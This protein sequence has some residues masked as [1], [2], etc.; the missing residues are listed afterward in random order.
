MGKWDKR[1]A[2][3]AEEQCLFYY[4]RAW[5][6]YHLSYQES[7][8]DSS[9]GKESVC[10]AGDPGSIPGQGRSAGEGTGYL[11]QYS[12]PY[13]V[14]QLV[15][16][17]PAMWKT[18]VRSLGWENPLEK[19]KATHSSILDWRNSTDCTIHGVI[20]SQTRLSNFHFAL[21]RE[22]HRM[23]DMHQL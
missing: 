2:S 13:L 7:F 4:S 6:V 20:K 15:K 16:N 12:W 1:K 14:A 18:W 17:P 10:K 8:P 22:L 23:I 11:L 9:V 19:G 5:P 21:F 3:W